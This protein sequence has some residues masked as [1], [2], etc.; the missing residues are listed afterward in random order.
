MLCHYWHFK[1]VGFTFEPHVCNICHD[2]LITA[3][4]FMS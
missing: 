3:H 2:A 1:D 4:E